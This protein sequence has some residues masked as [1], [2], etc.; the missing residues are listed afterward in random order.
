MGFG[1]FVTYEARHVFT[2]F[3]EKVFT[4]PNKEECELVLLKKGNAPVCVQVVGKAT[5]PGQECRIALIDITERKRSEVVI[6]LANEALEALCQAKEAEDLT[7]LVKEAAELL[8]Q[9]NETVDSID[10]VKRLF[11]SNMCISCEHR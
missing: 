3:L 8:R 9:A 4:S 5:K 6:R 2:A 1:L 10:L 11:H 7:H